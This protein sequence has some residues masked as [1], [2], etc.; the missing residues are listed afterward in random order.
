MSHKRKTDE[1]EKIYRPEK[2]NNKCV[3]K[4]QIPPYGALI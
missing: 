2:K 1:K 3:S 4:T